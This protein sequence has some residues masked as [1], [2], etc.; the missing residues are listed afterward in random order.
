[1]IV[2]KVVTKRK[3][4]RVDLLYCK[5]THWRN[6]TKIITLSNWFGYIARHV[7]TNCQIQSKV[8]VHPKLTVAR[9]YQNYLI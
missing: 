2:K 3:N 9:G 1:M 4:N 6:I 8:Q 5:H 7:Q